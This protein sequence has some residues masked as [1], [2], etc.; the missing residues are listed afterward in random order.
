VDGGQPS[1]GG[2]VEHS[3]E[4]DDFPGSATSSRSAA[5]APSREIPQA[6]RSIEVST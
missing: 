2:G 6:C 1:N 5:R 3:V 4:M